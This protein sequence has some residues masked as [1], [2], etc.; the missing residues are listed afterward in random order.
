MSRY[1]T[2][3]FESELS[4]VLPAN[5]DGAVSSVPKPNYQSPPKDHPIFAYIDDASALIEILY[6]EPELLEECRELDFLKRAITYF[7]NV[8]PTSKK[9]QDGAL[10]AE[11]TTSIMNTH[12]EEELNQDDIN[13][14]GDAIS[15]GESYWS[16]EDEEITDTNTH[17]RA[18]ESSESD[19]DMQQ[20]EEC[21][22]NQFTETFECVIVGAGAA[23]IGVGISLVCGG[24]KRKNMLIVSPSSFASFI[25]IIGDILV[26][27]NVGTVHIFIIKIVVISIV[28]DTIIFLFQTS[29]FVVHYLHL[30]SFLSLYLFDA[31]L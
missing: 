10:T 2:N 20:D 14:D 5:D 30:F 23:G 6:D 25:V 24:M 22:V 26:T 31:S 7:S 15:E 4:S 21:Q 11:A 17:V 29:Q 16:E 3:K 8:P 28:V 13:K 19:F 27:F 9:R 1:T 18:I 12:T